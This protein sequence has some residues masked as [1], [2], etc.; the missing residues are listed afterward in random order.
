MGGVQYGNNEEMGTA[1]LG[2]HYTN[3]QISNGEVVQTM[4]VYC[5]TQAT[6][7]LRRT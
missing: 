3:P 4:T 7:Y 2:R 1:G 5:V 6:H